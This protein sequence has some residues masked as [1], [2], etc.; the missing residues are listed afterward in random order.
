LK[1]LIP[2]DFTEANEPFVLFEAWFEEATEKEPSDPNAMALATSDADGVPDVRMVL[3]KSFGPDGFVFYSNA[4]SAK[5]VELQANMKAAGVL[6]WKSLRRQVRFRGTVEQATDA[7]ADAY[8]NSRARESRLGAWASQQSRPLESRFALEAAVAKVAL[9]YPL[10]DI[11]RP[12]YW[13]GYRIKPVSIEFWS[14]GPFRLH[15]RIQFRRDTP[16]ASW[17]KERLYP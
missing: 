4:Q 1:A 10:G 6:H 15:N 8:F 17:T 11:P 12:P 14:D 3:L 5:G 7:E 2:G 13:I 16:Q 9:T